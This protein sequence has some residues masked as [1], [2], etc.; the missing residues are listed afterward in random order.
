MLP[1]MAKKLRTDPSVTPE[2]RADLDA[3]RAD[4]TTGPVT[5][6]GREKFAWDGALV[7]AE[8]YRRLSLAGALPPR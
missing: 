3:V 1:A 4:H 7:S 5:I 6:G 8:D 2:V